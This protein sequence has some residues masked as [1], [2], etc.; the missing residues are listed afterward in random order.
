MGEKFK[1][2]PMLKG[3][4]LYRRQATGRP[5]D[6]KSKLANC[7]ESCVPICFQSGRPY[8]ADIRQ[9][10]NRGELALFLTKIDDGLR[11]LL[12]SPL[13]ESS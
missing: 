10:F 12:S 3:I 5:H 11:L 1:K 7:D 6:G 8:A 9:L 2:I 4:F 13:E